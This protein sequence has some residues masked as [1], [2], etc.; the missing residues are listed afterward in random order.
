M[1]VQH[2]R[3]FFTFCV[4]NT[5]VY[6][7]LSLCGP[8]GGQPRHGIADGESVWALGRPECEPLAELSPP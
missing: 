1:N 7:Y 4:K 8:I 2:P 5:L 6:Y 3:T